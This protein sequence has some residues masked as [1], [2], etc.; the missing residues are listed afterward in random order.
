MRKSGN[1]SRGRPIDVETREFSKRER[2]GEDSAMTKLVPPLRGA[3]FA[4][5]VGFLGF[6]G[7]GCA[8]APFWEIDGWRQ[9]VQEDIGA[10]PEEE[11][12]LFEQVLKEARSD[13]PF[14]HDEPIDRVEVGE[15]GFKFRG[16]YFDRDGTRV[17]RSPWQSAYVATNPRPYV[18]EFEEGNSIAKAFFVSMKGP[19]PRGEFPSLKTH[20]I[21]FSRPRDAVDCAVG[22]LTLKRLAQ[23]R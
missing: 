3:I 10:D 22:L 23:D 16:H 19:L 5:L 20:C 12:S 6:F 11:M 14:R 2:G 9:H 7:G 8:S 18:Y 15:E 17:R 4:V 13:V 21:W 1:Y